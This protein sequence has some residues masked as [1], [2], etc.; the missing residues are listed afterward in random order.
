M[1][2]VDHCNFFM[3]EIMRRLD[4]LDLKIEAVYRS[5]ERTRRYIL[6]MLITS[7]VFVLLPMIILL[8]V[9]P[10]FLGSMSSQLEGLL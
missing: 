9:I 7:L 3:E 1:L 4:A 5:A 2:A 10:A 8:F 6:W